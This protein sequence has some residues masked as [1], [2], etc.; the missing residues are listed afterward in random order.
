MTTNEML[1]TVTRIMVEE[2]QKSITN[3]SDG[4]AV[5]KDALEKYNQGGN[6]DFHFRATART[7]REKRCDCGGAKCKTT[8]ANWCSF[9]RGA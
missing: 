5:I 3:S 2:F 9:F 1:E 7:T 6:I 8:H 4:A